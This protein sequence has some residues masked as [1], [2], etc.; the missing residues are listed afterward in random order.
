MT[1]QIT[2]PDGSEAKRFDF[3]GYKEFNGEQITQ[4]EFNRFAIDILFEEYQIRG[5][6][7]YDKN[8]DTDNL[9]FNL[10]ADLG[11]S[12]VGFLVR[13]NNAHTDK[14]EEPDINEINLLAE[15]KGCIP[16]LAIANLNTFE[17]VGFWKPLKIGSNGFRNGIYSLYVVEFIYKSLL[18]DN[19]STTSEN[20]SN[21]DL[22]LI[23]AEAWNNLD[24]TK[25]KEFLEINFHYY[26]DWVFDVLPS[27]IEYLNYLEG[28]FETLRKHNIKPIFS[29]V[30]N[31]EG[32]LAL[33]FDQN[34]EKAIFYIKSN[35]GKITMA[36]MAKYNNNGDFDKNENPIEETDK[37]KQWWK[38]L[39]GRKSN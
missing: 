29:T 26:S 34:G 21:N 12:K 11:H 38:R 30:E 36:H 9:A 37:R 6:N 19:A 14:F 20:A 16:R 15:K 1:L 3:K 24:T 32:Q 4:E 7:V 5:V 17:T 2:T 8:Y 27:R 18:I 22:V 25:L 39:F 31:Q 13:L 33:L 10:I 35:N 28:K 23:F